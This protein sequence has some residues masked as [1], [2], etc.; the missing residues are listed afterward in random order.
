MILTHS[1]DVNFGLSIEDSVIGPLDCATSTICTVIISDIDDTG[2]AELHHKVVP[3]QGTDA[4]LIDVF[5]ALALIPEGGNQDFKFTLSLGVN[6]ILAL[7]LPRSPVVRSIPRPEHRRRIP[8]RLNIE[9]LTTA[10][11]CSLLR[12]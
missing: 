2:I 1:A 8:V 5:S 12:V 4:S 6:L 11:L 3:V 7:R 10:R 9:S